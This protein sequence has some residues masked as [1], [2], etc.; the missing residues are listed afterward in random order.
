M[1]LNT[2][3]AVIILIIFIS[4]FILFIIKFFDNAEEKLEFGN[5]KKIKLL[6]KD[7][8]F[9]SVRNYKTQILDN[10]SELLEKTK[11]L[12]VIFLKPIE[13][14]NQIDFKD[15]FKS[16]VNE[17]KDFMQIMFRPPYNYKLLII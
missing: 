5:I 4:L 1:A 9:E 10:K 8:I 17:L 6:T 13:I 11:N 16:T 14:K 3:V 15:L 12:K 2:F 7:E